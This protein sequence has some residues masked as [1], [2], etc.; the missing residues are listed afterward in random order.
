MIKHCSA[1]IKGFTDVNFIVRAGA[2]TAT[3]A[4]CIQ[5]VRHDG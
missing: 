4:S 5:K 3:A 2:A 1:T